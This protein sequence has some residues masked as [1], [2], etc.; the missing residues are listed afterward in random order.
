MR[1]I[2][3]AACLVASTLQAAEPRALFNGKDFTGWSFDLIDPAVAPE[4]I[5]T[6]KDGNVICNGRSLGVMRT[7]EDFENYELIIEWRWAPG[8]KPGNS[9]VLI[10]TS[11]PRE[12]S[13]WPK[14]IEVQLASGDAGDFWMIG[15][16]ISVVGAQAL[17]RRWVK[18][19]ESSEKPIGEW[20]T[21]RIRSEGLKI[22]VW[23]NGIL[24]NEATS[25]VAQRGAICLQSEGAE[26]HFRKVELTPIE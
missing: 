1:L 22:S 15:E 11:T 18:T 25:K 2:I 4:T 26:I 3:Y 6:V 19:G 9:G 12:M 16:E 5:W 10:H 7:N 21:A 14:S 20:N 13:V 23:I 24:T 17:G 8:S